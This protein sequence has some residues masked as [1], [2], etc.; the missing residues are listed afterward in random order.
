M[1]KI[2]LPDYVNITSKVVEINHV[3]GIL[4]IKPLKELGFVSG[5]YSTDQIMEVLP[6]VSE[7][8]L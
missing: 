1:G 2:E 6:S 5:E 8:V 7:E 4:A 3:T